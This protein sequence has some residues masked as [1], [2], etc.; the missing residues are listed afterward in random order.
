M[1]QFPVAM[2][3]SALSSSQKWRTFFL[4]GDHSDTTD[5]AKTH[6]RF[7]KHNINILKH[8]IV[9]IV[10]V[11][12]FVRLQWSIFTTEFFWCCCS[13]ESGER[14]RK[15]PQNARAIRLQQ[16]R[17]LYTEETRKLHS[18]VTQKSRVIL[19]KLSGS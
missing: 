12:Y 8:T 6:K 16:R 2:C 18:A 9:F 13:L 7:W 15:G 10:L 1:F 19:E 14:L 11:F 17:L 4:T 5:L 3:F